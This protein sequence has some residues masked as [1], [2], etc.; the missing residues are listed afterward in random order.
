VDQNFSNNWRMDANY[1][2]GSIREIGA[3]QADI[4]GLLRKKRRREAGCAGGP[5]A[6]A[7]V[8]RGWHHRPDLAPV[9]Q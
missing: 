7:T 9:P 4:S 6:R 1:R 2:F 8:P 5:A 3:A